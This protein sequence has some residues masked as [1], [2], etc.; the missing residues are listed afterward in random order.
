MAPGWRSR[1][2]PGVLE[3]PDL[4]ALLG[5]RVEGMLAQITF[6]Q[7]GDQTQ[8]QVPAGSLALQVDLKGGAEK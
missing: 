3:Q 7:E 4:E 1:R 6:Q 5:Q 8:T 2:S